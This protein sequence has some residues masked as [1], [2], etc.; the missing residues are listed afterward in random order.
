MPLLENVEGLKKSKAFL[1]LKSTATQFNYTINHDKVLKILDLDKRDDENLNL[2][3]FEPSDMLQQYEKEIKGLKEENDKLNQR[4]IDFDKRDENEISVLKLKIKNVMSEKENLEETNKMIED[5]NQ[6]LKKMLDIHKDNEDNLKAKDKIIS[7]LKEQIENLT[8]E[9]KQKQNMIH[10]LENILQEYKRKLSESLE[11]ENNPSTRK[12][13]GDNQ[14]NYYNSNNDMQN[15]YNSYRRNNQSRADNNYPCPNFSSRTN[16]SSRTNQFMN[17]QN[18][19]NA[20][21]KSASSNYNKDYLNN[22][23]VVL[24]ACEE[25]QRGYNTSRPNRGEFYD[26][27]KESMQNEIDNLDQEI[28]TLKNKLNKIVS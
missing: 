25:S 2:D 6:G 7:K 27:T 17:S 1:E 12:N 4:I 15:Y 18:F 14:S 21:Y 13:Y 10:S 20:D 28:N 22:Q 16:Y 8:T 9:N 23:F 3:K 19:E 24:K 11:Q 5:M 26:E